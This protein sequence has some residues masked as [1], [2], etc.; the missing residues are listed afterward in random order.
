MLLEEGVAQRSRAAKQTCQVFSNLSP[1]TQKRE[2]S[3]GGE[4]RKNEKRKKESLPILLKTAGTN[5]SQKQYDRK[6]VCV[7][8]GGA[9]REE[10]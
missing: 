9:G 3:N 1:T 5:T 4:K 6:E 7:C 2:S 8:V 10:T